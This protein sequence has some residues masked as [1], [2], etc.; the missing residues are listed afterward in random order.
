MAERPRELGDFTELGDFMRVGQFEAIFYVEVLRF[1]PIY[2]P[3]DWGIV[4][5]QL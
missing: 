1:A 2:G 5:L 4:I 3:F